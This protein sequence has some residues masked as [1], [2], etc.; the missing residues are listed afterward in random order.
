[1]LVYRDHGLEPTRMSI[2]QLSSDDY[3]ADAREKRCKA[4]KGDA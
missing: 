4:C 1:M 3:R 2:V